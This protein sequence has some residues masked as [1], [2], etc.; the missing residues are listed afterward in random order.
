M[1]KQDKYEMEKRSIL[2]IY[3]NMCT[4][5]SPDHKKYRKKI[6][7]KIAKRK[8]IR[9]QACHEVSFLHPE[10]LKARPA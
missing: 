5:R 9:E 6:T 1:K 2:L 10:E 7:R 8:A 3:V 4:K